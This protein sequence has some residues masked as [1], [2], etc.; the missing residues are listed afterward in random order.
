MEFLFNRSDATN[1]VPEPKNKSRTKASFFVENIIGLS[2]NFKGI[3]H[4]CAFL[5]V[6]GSSIAS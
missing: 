2:T 6:F 5:F 1:V 3:W 4:G